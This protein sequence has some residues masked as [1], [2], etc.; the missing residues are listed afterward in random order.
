MGSQTGTADRGESPGRP[1]PRAARSK[2]VAIATAQQLLAEQGWTAVTH[3]A[4]AA[5]S[6]I[7]RTTLYRHWPDATALIRD[8]IAQCLAVVRPRRTGQLRTDLG[9]ELEALR[10]LLHDPVG[11]R[12]TRAL[13]ERTGVEP[14]LTRLREALCAASLDGF[15]VVVEEAKSRGELPSGLS[16][17]L[18]VDQLAGPLAFRRL[19]T[20][21]PVPPDYVPTLVDT[22]LRCHGAA[23]PDS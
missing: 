3:V 18:A 11:E 6:G 4:V 12:G 7:G 13:I 19:F 22:F 2:A 23:A 15:R 21:Q 14:E 5:R 1:D 20:D 10:R 17:E 8:A 9:Q 16:T